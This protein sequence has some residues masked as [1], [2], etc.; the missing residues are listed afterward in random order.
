MIK[1]TV[2]IHPFLLAVYPVLF[3]YSHNSG[4]VAFRETFAP[5]ALILGFTLPVWGILGFA[6][7]NWKKSGIIV[8]LF[9]ILF[10]SY[11]NFRTPLEGKWPVLLMTSTW[12]AIFMLGSFY[13]AAS[14]KDFTKATTILNIIASILIAL[15]VLNIIVHQF[16]N[17]KRTSHDDNSMPMQTDSQS[18]IKKLS[19][20]D[21]YF[22]VLDSY[23][24]QDIL[25][26]HFI[27]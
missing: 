24:R 14:R 6:L 25:T 23:A 8:S 2:V 21:I 19:Y 10:F 9:L 1:K 22:I 26:S 15:P 18:T 13:T 16:S 27:T 7:K 20:P 17:I 3:L 11:G 12:I 5:I 4:E